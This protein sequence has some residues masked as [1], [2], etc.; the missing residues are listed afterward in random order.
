MLKYLALD[1]DNNVIEI[2]FERSAELDR[3]NWAWRRVARDTVACCYADNWYLVDVS[4]VLLP[5][6]HFG[7]AFESMVFPHGTTRDI[8]ATRYKTH[9]EAV[10]GHAKILFDVAEQNFEDFY[11]MDGLGVDEGVE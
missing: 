8:Y 7:Y 10:E 1:K 4:T 6:D 2:S 3:T 9:K 11:G 5:I